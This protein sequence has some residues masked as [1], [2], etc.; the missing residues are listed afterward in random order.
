M[1]GSE[2]AGGMFFSAS[3][4][5]PP[6]AASAGEARAKRPAEETLPTALVIGPMRAGT[7]WM[8]DYLVWRGDVCL[9][10][11]VKETFFFDHYFGRGVRWYARHFRH[12]DPH[13]HA[14]IVEVAP[15]L[16]PD[17]GAPA[18]VRAVIGGRPLV[19]VVRDPV[20]RAWSHY[21]H[22]RRKGYTRAPLAAAL[23]EYP[24]IVEA[25]RYEAHI[26][27]WQAALPNSPVT[28][29]RLADL[30]ADRRAYA[31]QLC[32]ALGLPE[33]PPPDGLGEANSGGAA[34]SFRMAQAGR[35]MATVLRYAGGH[36]VV[37]L[38]RRAGLKKVFYGADGGRRIR[39]SPEELAL[40][41]AALDP[42]RV[43]GGS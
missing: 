21:Q 19:V 23:K 26:A 31:A 39:P 3:G 24:Q 11:G 33:M 14:A 40:L 18:R 9:P 1:Q 13:G 7:T 5:H 37:N 30:V 36:A 6:G 34:P 38:A 28:V 4:S 25:S 43:G 12:F 35:R 27:R 2:T 29:L 41:R 22:L 42:F 20:E 15:S 32:R 8:H 16:F 17:A 10:K